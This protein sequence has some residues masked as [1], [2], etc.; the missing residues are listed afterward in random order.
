MS[1]LPFVSW[2]PEVLAS[3]TG[4]VAA[5]VEEAKECASSTT[6]KNAYDKFLRRCSSKEHFKPSLS[7]ERG[8]ICLPLTLL[9]FG[10]DCFATNLLNAS[11]WHLFQAMFGSMCRALIRLVASVA[12]EACCDRR[13]EAYFVG[14]LLRDKNELFNLWLENGMDFGKVEMVYER[15]RTKQD[16][17]RL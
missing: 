6:H 13:R 4:A 3:A 11:G 7:G 8:E 15:K 1:R 12:P 16:R 5:M 17:C 10:C 9:T 2:Q 14:E